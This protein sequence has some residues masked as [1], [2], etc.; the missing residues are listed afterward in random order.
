MVKAASHL[1]TSAKPSNIAPSIARSGCE[2]DTSSRVQLSALNWQK[3]CVI[4][5]A[6]L[7]LLIGCNNAIEGVLEESFERL[8][9]M[10]PS[11]FMAQT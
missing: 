4:L 7:L 2:L 10:E 11:W 3:L 1:S 8:Y 5:G 6:P 9:T